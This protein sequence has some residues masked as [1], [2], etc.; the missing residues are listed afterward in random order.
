MWKNIKGK[1][2]FEVKVTWNDDEVIRIFI[3][4]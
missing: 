2:R 3:V 1:C 4:E